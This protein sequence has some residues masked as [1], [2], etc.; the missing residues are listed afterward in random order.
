[1]RNRVPGP[2][3]EPTSMVAHQSLLIHLG[4]PDTVE[5]VSHPETRLIVDTIAELAVKMRSPTTRQK[6]KDRVRTATECP[7]LGHHA[8]AHPNIPLSTYAMKW[9][10]IRG[11]AH[12]N[13]T[14][15]IHGEQ[16]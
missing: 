2:P 6:D 11:T 10:G 1:M 13:V 5:W 3:Q 16:Y 14:P 7:R 12:R 15:T 4:P 9:T 8:M